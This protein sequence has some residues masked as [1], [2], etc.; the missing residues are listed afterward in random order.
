MITQKARQAMRHTFCRS[1]TDPKTSQHWERWSFVAPVD[2]V[3]TVQEMREVRKV[4]T[5][6]KAPTPSLAG[7]VIF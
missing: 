6:S 4:D 7:G 3:M 1:Y 2:R 5:I